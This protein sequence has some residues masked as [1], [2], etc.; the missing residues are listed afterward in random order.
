VCL[1]TTCPVH[2]SIIYRLAQG[3]GTIIYPCPRWSTTTTRLSLVAV[4]F[5]CIYIELLNYS[6]TEM[7]QHNWQ[8][9]F[10]KNQLKV[11]KEPPLISLFN[12]LG[13]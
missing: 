4:H 8:D 12:Q 13:C 6:L 7:K 5:C 2:L 11:A 3:Q 9:M 10:M 1:K